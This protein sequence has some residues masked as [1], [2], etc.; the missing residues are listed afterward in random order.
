MQSCSGTRSDS[1]AHQ[2]SAPYNVMNSA[3][4]TAEKLQDIARY[5]AAPVKVPCHQRP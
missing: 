1:W 4:G 2:S 3:R 5:R